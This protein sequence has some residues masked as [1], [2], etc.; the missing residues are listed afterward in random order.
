MNF[1]FKIGGAKMRAAEPNGKRRNENLSRRRHR[2]GFIGRGMFPQPQ[3]VVIRTGEANPARGLGIVHARAGIAPFVDFRVAVGEGKGARHAVDGS[4]PVHPGRIVHGKS[5]TGIVHTAGRLLRQHPQIRQAQRARMIR[6]FRVG[7]PRRIADV[8]LEIVQPRTVFGQRR[9]AAM[10]N[11]LV[12]AGADRA[13]CF[14]HGVGPGRRDHLANQIGI[15]ALV[16]TAPRIARAF[17]NAAAAGEIRRDQSAFGIFQDVRIKFLRVA[18]ARLSGAPVVARNAI[19]V[20]RVG[21]QKIVVVAGI[22]QDRQHQ[23]PRV[24]HAKRGLGA[25]FCLAQCRQQ[26][27]GENRKNG[28]DH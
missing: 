6:G 5:K 23:L 10:P 17:K 24:V 9:R 28:D 20:I 27:S 21:R 25:G 16:N 13:D 11:A 14:A 22:G 3:P 2:A 4:G 15:T 26:Q 12:V 7:Q 18:R 19:A 1:I 8:R